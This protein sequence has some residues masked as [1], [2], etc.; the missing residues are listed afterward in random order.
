MATLLE[1][2]KMNTVA[3]PDRNAELHNAQ[4]SENYRLLRDAEERQFASTEEE[5]ATAYSSVRASVLAP[6]RPA[7]AQT[8]VAPVAPAEFTH[9]RVESP[10]FTTET[11]DRAIR[12]NAPVAPVTPIAPVEIQPA[13][14]EAIAQETTFALS[15][16]AKTVAAVF[17]AV[18]VM[19]L[20]LI[21][22][23][24]QIINERAA[25]ISELES[26]QR[27]LIQRSIKLRDQIEEATS[28]E[29]IEEFA[30]Q[31]GMVKAE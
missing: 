19:M 26:E 25:R 15:S 24:T 22:I 14:T 17:A 8:P 21:C 23:N 27:S 31:H 1:N 30:L 28:E 7:E 13:Q 2:Q 11:L 29:N 3:A 5:K 20:T 10:L 16:F 18:V 4:I 9:E 6:E 12:N